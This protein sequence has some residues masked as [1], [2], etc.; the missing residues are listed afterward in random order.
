MIGRNF[1]SEL[2]LD[3]QR[4]TH[5]RAARARRACRRILKRKRTVVLLDDLL[6]DRQT[7]SG[8]FGARRNVRFEEFGAVL[9]R[10]SNS[11]VDDLD[12]D[13]VARRQEPD[14][15]LALVAGWP[16]LCLAVGFDC[17]GSVLDEVRHSL[18]NEPQIE[19]GAHR[20]IGN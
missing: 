1:V 7:Q 12:R 5:K 20:L 18:R 17:L 10:Q 3:R 13:P 4:H 9:F 14:F 6:Y 19:T 15:N 2:G 11:V 8:A 16:P